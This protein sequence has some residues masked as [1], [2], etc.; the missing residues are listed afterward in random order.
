[1]II[2]MMMIFINHIGGGHRGK[3]KPAAYARRGQQPGLPHHHR[4][5]VGLQPVDGHREPHVHRAALR[6]GEPVLP[7]HVVPADPQM[8]R[9]NICPT[10]STFEKD[11]RGPQRSRYA[12]SSGLDNLV[13]VT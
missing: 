2:I 10:N 9:V 6:R 4:W 11:G 1:M 8:L 7:E 5:D 12:L 3:A 13:Q